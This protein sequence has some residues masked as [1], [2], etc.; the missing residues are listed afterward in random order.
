[1]PK[2]RKEFGSKG[3]NKGA[4]KGEP[5]KVPPLKTVGPCGNAARIMTLRIVIV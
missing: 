1:M 5:E 4:K 3:G 2:V